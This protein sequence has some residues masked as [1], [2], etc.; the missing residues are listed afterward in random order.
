[1]WT[2]GGGVPWAEGTAKA[3]SLRQC[4]GMF[5]GEQGS[6]HDSLVSSVEQWWTVEEL[7]FLK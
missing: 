2:A 5:Q 4:S 7:R 3:K 6:L 1:M